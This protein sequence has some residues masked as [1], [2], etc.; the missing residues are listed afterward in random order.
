MSDEVT[1]EILTT[2]LLEL[3]RAGKRLD[4]RGADEY[5]PIHVE[6]GFVA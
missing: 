5:R 1:A 6:P 3:A 4:G 2:H